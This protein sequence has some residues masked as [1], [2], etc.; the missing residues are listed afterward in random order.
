MENF[1]QLKLKRRLGRGKLPVD[2]AFEKPG[3]S[4]ASPS[5]PKDGMLI[6]LIVRPRDFKIM[7]SMVVLLVVLLMPLCLLG[8]D[9]S[10]TN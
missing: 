2:I 1:E 3:L 8:A 4:N 10:E 9:K 6:S 5:S 7:A